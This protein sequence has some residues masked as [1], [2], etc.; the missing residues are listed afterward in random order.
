M[1]VQFEAKSPYFA[2]CGGTRV[3]TKA[4]PSASFHGSRW[5]PANTGR[6]HLVAGILA[7][8]FSLPAPAFSQEESGSSAS[9]AT[10]AGQIQA[11]RVKKAADLAPEGLTPGEK[12]L[13]TFKHTVE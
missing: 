4:K 1:P 3:H 2:Q 8:M 13:T 6:V 10:R 11:E 9:S 7:L 5:I 12:D